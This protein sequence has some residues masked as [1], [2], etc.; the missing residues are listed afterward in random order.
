MKKIIIV[1]I[2]FFLISISISADEI[3]IP[4]EPGSY[5]IVVYDDEGNEEEVMILIA[6][7]STVV[8]N[9]TH[10]AINASDFRIV[11]SAFETLTD[12]D[13]LAYSNATAWN[14]LTGIS[15]P[16][17][18][19]SINTNEKDIYTVKLTTINDTEKEITIY[20]TD[21]LGLDLDNMEITENNQ[22]FTSSRQEL[23]FS[24]IILMFFPLVLVSLITFIIKKRN[25]IIK[26]VLYKS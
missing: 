4:I 25:D 11:R 1:I 8:N 3:D 6:Y 18:V 9:I 7:P 20:V 14:M 22:N 21:Y 19:S 16:L 10:E 26:E 12:S 24:F 23:T 15:I 2:L 13:I 5:P 17:Q